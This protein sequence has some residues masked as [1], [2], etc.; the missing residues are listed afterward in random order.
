MG[1]RTR[2]QLLIML[3]LVPALLL[4]LHLNLEQR[5][6]GVMR[7]ENDAIR[8]AQ[9]AAAQQY[10]L[11]D[12]ARKHLEGLAHFPEARG[13]N[14]VSYNA[15]FAAK[16]VNPDYTDFGMIETNGDLVSCA[17]P[18]NGPTNLADRAH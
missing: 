3:P 6:F 10:A 2:L 16:K 17:I 8:L 7:V 11:I 4:A 13:T 1:L 14:V 12:G 18:R 15:F 9:L 5:R